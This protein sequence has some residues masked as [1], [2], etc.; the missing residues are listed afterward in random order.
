[1]ANGSKALS[2]CAQVFKEV[3]RVKGLPE[4]LRLDQ[5]S[6]RNKVTKG[7]AYWYWDKVRNTI[8]CVKNPNA[9]LEENYVFIITTFNGCLVKDC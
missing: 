5:N 3:D 8:H 7:L 6:Y 4:D 2:L 1:M 9:D